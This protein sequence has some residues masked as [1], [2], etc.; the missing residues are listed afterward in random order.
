MQAWVL[1]LVIPLDI[2]VMS[3][4]FFHIQ[5]ILV[6]FHIVYPG[7]LGSFSFELL[8]IHLQFILNTKDVFL[9]AHTIIYIIIS[10]ISTLSPIFSWKTCLGTLLTSLDP[11]MFLILPRSMPGNLSFSIT[12]NSQASEQYK[13]TGWA[14]YL[15]IYPW[16]LVVDPTFQPK[17]Y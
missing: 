11:P 6:I 17:Y 4:G 7:F 14:Q 13:G 2:S 15:K 3:I 8:T 1:N 9:P 12:V 5:L 10:C 16:F